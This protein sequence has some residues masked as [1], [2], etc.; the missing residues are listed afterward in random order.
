ML[1]NNSVRMYLEHDG[2][3][4]DEVKAQLYGKAKFGAKT[5]HNWG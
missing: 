3:S 1:A 2:A 4:S 5:L